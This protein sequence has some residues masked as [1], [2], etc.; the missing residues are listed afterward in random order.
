M[1]DSA[2]L[3]YCLDVIAKE[4]GW[5]AYRVLPIGRVRPGRVADLVCERARVL[6][7]L[8]PVSSFRGN[9]GVRM[10]GSYYQRRAE[11]MLEP[12]LRRI[13]LAERALGATVAFRSAGYKKIRGGEIVFADYD[14]LTVLAKPKGGRQQLVSFKNGKVTALRDRLIPVLHGAR[15]D[16][17]QR[18]E[19]WRGVGIAD[20]RVADAWLEPLLPRAA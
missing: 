16:A 13:R 15:L 12:G 9:L 17:T 1:I 5:F 8:G 19:G 14:T 4:D 6:E 7:C 10:L 2:A 20:P 18:G 11:F 3:D